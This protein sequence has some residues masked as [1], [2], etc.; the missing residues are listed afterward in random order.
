MHSYALLGKNG[1]GKSVLLKCLLGVLK[2]DGG[3]VRTSIGPETAASSAPDVRQVDATTTVVS[4]EIGFAPQVR[5]IRLVVV[6]RSRGLVFDIIIVFWRKSAQNFDMMKSMKIYQLLG[7]VGAVKGLSN[8]ETVER[9]EVM[10]TTIRGLPESDHSIGHLRFGSFFLFVRLTT[11]RAR[12]IAPVSV[13]GPSGAITPCASSHGRTPRVTVVSSV[14]P[15]PPVYLHVTKI[16]R[17]F[18]LP[19]S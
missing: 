11:D 3:N 15:C 8:D 1:A 13:G 9:Y 18:V 19:N 10:A 5:G 2:L 16:T 12:C 7:L 17:Q 14:G 4:P 6:L